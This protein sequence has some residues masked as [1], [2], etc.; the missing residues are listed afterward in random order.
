MANMRCD[1]SRTNY[2]LAYQVIVIMWIK[3][4]V[5][6]LQPRNYFKRSHSCCGMYLGAGK[7]SAHLS[8][9]DVFLKCGL[10]SQVVP[11]MA[12]KFT[13]YEEV[14]NLMRHRSGSKDLNITDRFVSGS[15]AGIISQ[16]V[17]FPLEVCWSFFY[18]PPAYVPSIFF[19]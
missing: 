18:F 14:K 4:G 15:I 19:S 5:T 11:E 16:S 2:D 10:S 6:Q 8:H 7:F 3:G 9:S 12:V 1:V 13:V 17:V